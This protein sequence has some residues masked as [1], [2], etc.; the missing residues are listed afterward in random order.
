MELARGEATPTRNLPDDGKT[1]S[2]FTQT[3]SQYLRPVD[4][5]DAP[6]SLPLRIRE[7]SIT[8][9]GLESKGDLP[10]YQLMA[11][12]D[13]IFGVYQDLVHQ[14]PGIHVD[15]GIEYDGKW[16]QIRNKII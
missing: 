4:A 11:A 15:G 7:D 14:N 10:R 6:D 3:P 2:L 9:A 1:P 12:D 13:N 16:K 8:S 5:L